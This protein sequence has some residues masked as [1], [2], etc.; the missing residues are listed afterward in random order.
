MERSLFSEKQVLGKTLVCDKS[1]RHL[2]HAS[3]RQFLGQGCVVGKKSNLLKL[4]NTK[5]TFRTKSLLML[6]CRAAT[7]S[8]FLAFLVQ[9]EVAEKIS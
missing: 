8:G 7:E 9:P 1:L 6:F 3:E 4:K 5:Q 2:R